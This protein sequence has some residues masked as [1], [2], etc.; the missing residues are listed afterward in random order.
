MSARPLAAATVSF[1]LV[2]IPVKL[3]SAA[4]PRSAVSFNQINKKDGARVKQQLVSSASGELV[5]REDIV[6]GYEFSKGQYVLFE[7]EE[8]KALE[9]AA[10]QTIDI[11]EFLPAEQIDR[12]Y[13]DKVYYL[14]PDKGGPRAYKLLAQ[15][16]AET[17]RVAIGKYAARGKH[18]PEVRAGHARGGAEV[19]DVHGRAGAEGHGAEEE[20]Y[21]HQMF[22]AAATSA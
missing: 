20:G 14:G 2:S 12:R 4:E 13:L 16:L 22:S 21:A 7:P 10:T 9:A 19:C 5:A 6:K 3:Y 11:V 15:A 17:G 1:G 8:L 18:E